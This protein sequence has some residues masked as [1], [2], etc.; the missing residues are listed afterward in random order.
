MIDTWVKL[1]GGLAVGT[2]PKFG[3]NFVQTA[4]TD[5]SGKLKKLFQFGSMKNGTS[6]VE[7]EKMETAIDKAE[8]QVHCIEEGALS[9]ATD[10]K[11]SPDALFEEPEHLRRCG[12]KK[13]KAMVAAKKKGEKQRNLLDLPLE[14]WE[15]L[16]EDAKADLVDLYYA[17]KKRERGEKK[18]KREREEAKKAA[19]EAKKAAEVA[20]KAAKEA[21]KAAEVAKKAAFESLTPEQQQEEVKKKEVLAGYQVRVQGEEAEGAARLPEV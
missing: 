4:W 3:S 11:N 9:T 2:T 1:L 8:V 16:D 7:H 20:K 18:K 10:K 13:A 17:E 14:V 15:L 5:S 21:K 6:L 19:K 12:S